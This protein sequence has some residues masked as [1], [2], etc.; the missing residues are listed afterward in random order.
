MTNKSQNILIIYDYERVVQPFMQT[1]IQFAH[2]RFHH[3]YFITPPIPLIYKKTIDY[4]NVHIV[5][6]TKAQRIKQ[7]IAGVFSPLRLSFWKEILKGTVDLRI[8]KEMGQLYFAASGFKMMSENIIKRHLQ[9]NDK[10]FLLGTWMG[11]DAYVA[12]LIKK[13]YPA[14]KGAYALAHSGEVMPSR[15]PHLKQCFHEYKHKYLDKVYF[16]SSKVL[17]EYYEGMASY[18]IQQRFGQNIAVHY[19]G[20]VN[21]QMLRNPLN[22]SGIFHILS[23][24]RIDKNKRIERIASALKGWNN[25]KIKWTHIG[26]GPT[27]DIVKAQAKETSLNNHFVEVEFTGRLDNK[28]VCKYY[29]EKP[30]D[31][32]INV[33]ESEGLPVSIMEAMSFGIPCIATNV[34]GTSEIVNDKNGILINIDFSDDELRKTI[35]KFKNMSNNER[36]TFRYNSGQ[37]WATYFNA[38]NNSN[39]LIDEWLK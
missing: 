2:T 11:V 25:G 34:G 6:W 8:F 13:K 30:V 21:K 24:S 5:L 10:I 27:E 3:I 15:N 37:T 17:S 7:Y 9:S 31:L 14:I 28:A 12:A 33:S 32:F 26:S 39:K 18:N 16:I 4:D 1:L 19:L 23:C 29:T 35:D 20:S 38:E 36:E 22:E